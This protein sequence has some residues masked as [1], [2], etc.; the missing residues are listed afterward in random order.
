MKAIAARAIPI[1]ENLDVPEVAPDL[2]NVDELKDAAEEKADDMKEMA[3][4]AVPGGGNMQLMMMKMW[5]ISKFSCCF[6]TPEMNK[7]GA[8][9]VMDDGEVKNKW[10]VKAP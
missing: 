8:L 3:A 9:D 7:M 1:P 2:P 6:G 5:I 4:D 10:L